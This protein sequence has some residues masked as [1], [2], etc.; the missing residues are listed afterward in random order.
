MR[1]HLL[2]VCLFAAGIGL[3]YAILGRYVD[4]ANADCISCDAGWYK[5]IALNGYPEVGS[6]EDLGHWQGTDIHQTEWAFFP[7]YPWLVRTTLHATGLGVGQVYMVLGALL[8][9]LLA[10]MAYHLF[11]YMQGATSAYWGVLALLSQPFG[12][13]FHLGMTEALFLCALLGCFLAVKKRWPWGLAFCASILVLTRPNG[14]FLLPVLVLYANELDGNPVSSLWRDP[15]GAFQRSWPLL[16]PL[17]AFAGWCILQWHMTGE[18][19]AFSAAQ[20]GWGRSLTWPFKGFFNAGDLATQFDS[21]F[22]IGLLGVA[23]TV[24]KQLPPS[25]NLLLWVSILLPLFSGSVA[26]MPR[27]TTVLF[28]LFLLAGNWLAGQRWKVPILAM[29]FMLQLG[30]FVLWLKGDLLTC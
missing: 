24:R 1:R 23:F 22:T 2:L 7:L 25:L 4:G 13:Y 27:F 21:W 6:G 30:W 12:I 14:L 20:A 16:F 18:P 29:A 26:S 9:A 11:S 10:L 28:P 3:I 5:R 17:A 19:F 15:M 8:S